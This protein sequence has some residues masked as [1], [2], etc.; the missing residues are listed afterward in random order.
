MG[1]GPY[2]RAP[3]EAVIA[4]AMAM[5][6]VVGSGVVDDRLREGLKVNGLRGT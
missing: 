2:S 6:A 3:A 5:G 1:Q 4:L